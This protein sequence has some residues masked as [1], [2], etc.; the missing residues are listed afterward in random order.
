MEMDW[1]TNASK[2]F[3]LVIWGT[4]DQGMAIAADSDYTNGLQSH[5]PLTAR[6]DDDQNRAQ[7]SG[8][9]L[10]SENPRLEGFKTWYSNFESFP[11]NQCG[12]HKRWLIDGRGHVSYAIMGGCGSNQLRLAMTLTQ[13]QWDDSWLSEGSTLMETIVTGV[14]I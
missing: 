14:G 8:A 10:C 4:S 2:D 3:S 7:E 5:W 12:I 6:Q 11:F 13:E 1:K 9:D